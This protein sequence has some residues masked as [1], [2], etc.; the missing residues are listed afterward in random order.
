VLA[1]VPADAPNPTPKSNDDE[2]GVR[3]LLVSSFCPSSAIA[4]REPALDVCSGCRRVF[5][6]RGVARPILPTHAFAT[7]NSG[8]SGQKQRHGLLDKLRHPQPVRQFR[9]PLT[10][11]LDDRVSQEG[12]CLRIVSL[13]VNDR[14]CRSLAASAIFLDV[15]C[16]NDL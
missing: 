15:G 10:L 12:A 11:R 1:D 13:K 2:L 7:D 9:Q 5:R 6:L 4:S 3:C 16:A 14:V 8:R